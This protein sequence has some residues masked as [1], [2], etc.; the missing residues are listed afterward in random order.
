MVVSLTLLPISSRSTSV[1]AIRSMS[2]FLSDLWFF[3]GPTIV[4]LLHFFNVK[5]VL[6]CSPPPPSCSDYSCLS[7]CWEVNSLPPSVSMCSISA[8]SFIACSFYIVGLVVA[9]L[10]F[11]SSRTHVTFCDASLQL[12]ELIDCATELSPPLLVSTPSF[13]GS[14]HTAGQLPMLS[15][16]T[17]TMAKYGNLCHL[18]LGSFLALIDTTWKWVL[19]SMKALNYSNKVGDNLG[20]WLAIVLRS[21]SIKT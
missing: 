14:C 5:G 10:L 1:T 11:C 12:C 4:S 21:I 18:C 19:N 7:I 13:V 2:I 9:S 17:L 20:H 15:C 6:F 8:C 16:T 3:L